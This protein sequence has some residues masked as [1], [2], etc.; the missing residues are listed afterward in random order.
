MLNL[1][2]FI[3]APLQ[4]PIRISPEAEE[5]VVADNANVNNN[6]NNNNEES[7]H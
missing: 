5:A 1:T 2:L 6:N 7:Q 4:G 3:D